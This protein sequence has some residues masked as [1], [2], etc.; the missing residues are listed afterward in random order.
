MHYNAFSLKKLWIAIIMLDF[1]KSASSSST[2]CQ[3]LNSTDYIWEVKASVLF[4]HLP[5]TLVAQVKQKV[6]YV[7]D[8]VLG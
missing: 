6:W 7:C 1:S 2:F 4:L 8:R 3:Q 5:T